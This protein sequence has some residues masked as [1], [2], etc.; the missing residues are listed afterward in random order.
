MGAIALGSPW[1]QST[2]GFPMAHGEKVPGF[3][4]AP[5]N[6]D[7]RQAPYYTD[8]DQSPYFNQ[9]FAAMYDLRKKP[10]TELEKWYH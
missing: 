2:S 10:L 4:K 8:Y 6:D 1:L 7:P 5:L 9:L 3:H